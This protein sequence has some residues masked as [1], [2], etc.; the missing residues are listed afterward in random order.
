MM[1]FFEH[2]SLGFCWWDI[3]SLIVLLAVTACFFIKRHKLKEE[4][5]ELQDQLSK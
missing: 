1:E 3:P 2:A 5:K 4:K